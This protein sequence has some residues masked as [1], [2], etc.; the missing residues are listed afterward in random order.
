MNA[1][2]ESPRVRSAMLDAALGYARRGW[3]VFPLH[4]IDG[5]R[6]SCIGMFDRS[7]CPGPEGKH[8]IFK[9]GTDHEAGTTVEF[10]IRRWWRDWP[11]ANIA[12]VTGIYSGLIVLDVDPKNGGLDSLARLQ[13]ERGSFPPTP[14]VRTPS[15][16]LHFYFKHP[17]R[18]QI[19]GTVGVLP[20]IDWR[21]DGNYVVAPP[22]ATLKGGYPWQ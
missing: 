9:T 3:R 16:G 18:E 17:G 19:K 1:T 2:A 10:L 13:A 12:I 6:C 8:P 11:N 22:S 21:A 5:D 14:T 20:G 7:A 15:G 4:W